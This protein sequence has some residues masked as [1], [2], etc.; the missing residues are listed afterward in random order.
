MLRQRLLLWVAVLPLLAVQ[1]LRA[2]TVQVGTCK[3]HTASYPTISA[4]VSN[5][6]PGST[7]QVCPGTYAESS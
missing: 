1:P 5:V 3:N 7:V 2:S 4:A 6:T